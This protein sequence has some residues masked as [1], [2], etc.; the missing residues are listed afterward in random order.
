MPLEDT[1]VLEGMLQGPMPGQSEAAAALEAMGPTLGGKNAHFSFQREGRRFSLL[2]DEETHDTRVFHPLTLSASIQQALEKIMGLL[3]PPERTQVFSTLR[4]REYRMGCE[5]QTVY[6]IFPPGMVQV[7]SRDT[8]A[9]VQTRPQAWTRKEKILLG[10]GAA[11]ILGLAAGVSTLFVDYRAMFGRALTNIRGT[12]LTEL[13][14]DAAPLGEYVKVEAKELNTAKD[15]LV[16]TLSRGPKWEE[17]LKSARPAANADWP[18][19]LAIEALQKKYAMVFLI[20]TDGRVVRSSVL[21][22]DGLIADE[23]CT[24]AVEFGS[25]RVLRKVVVRP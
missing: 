17:G 15:T 13:K 5:Q 12:S 3:S 25:G 6:Q 16:L 11:G 20:D 18:T 4:C 21:P 1:Y 22:L 7:Q 9:N 10:M 2:A 19:A 8:P 23:Q 24:F 14:V